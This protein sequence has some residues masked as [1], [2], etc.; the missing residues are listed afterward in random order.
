MMA[1]TQ[2]VVLIV[3]D[4]ASTR[5]LFCR[6]LARSGIGCVEA[7]GIGEALLRLEEDPVPGA[8]ILD[9]T[10][11]DASGAVLL[12][13]IRRDPTPIR[14]AIVTGVTDPK[15]LADVERLRPDRVFTK[16]ID[17]R[18]LIAWLRED[19]GPAAG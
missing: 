15:R 9:L 2:L 7:A 11:P 18:E 6:A 4:D 5:E 8:V 12:K 10:L 19:A 14:V 13:R 17:L 16:P 1:A 3:E